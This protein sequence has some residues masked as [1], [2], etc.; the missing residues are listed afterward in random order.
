MLQHL[1]P[2]G[3]DLFWLNKTEMKFSYSHST[4]PEMHNGLQAI[5]CS[6]KCQNIL[7]RYQFMKDTQKVTTDLP[8]WDGR[9]FAKWHSQ[10]ILSIQSTDVDFSKISCRDCRTTTGSSIHWVFHSTAL[11][12]TWSEG[13]DR[14]KVSRSSKVRGKFLKGRKKK[15]N[16]Q[17]S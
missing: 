2:C 4:S 11:K 9:F 7:D 17:F 10:R 13:Q 12:S 3:F 8:M 16:R 6:K 15:K 14:L 5:K 1:S